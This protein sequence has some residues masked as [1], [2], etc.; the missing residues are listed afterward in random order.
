MRENYAQDIT[1]NIYQMTPYPSNKGQYEHDFIEYANNDG[2]V[3][4]VAKIIENRH[5]FV[6]FRYIREDGLPAQYIPDFFVRFGSDVYIV[7]T[8]AQDQVSHGNVVRKQKSA[9]RW[10]ERTNSL[11]LDKREGITWHYVVLGDAIF[12]DWRNK[13]MNLLDILKFAE[14]RNDETA[15]WTGRLF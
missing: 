13:R 5:T 12:Y 14:L 3:D 15:E 4:A 8:K 11:P 9:L 7:E 2:A 6:R 1:K 10:V